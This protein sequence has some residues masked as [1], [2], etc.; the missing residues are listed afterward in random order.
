MAVVDE[1]LDVLG[2]NGVVRNDAPWNARLRAQVEWLDGRGRVVV[3]VADG[4]TPPVVAPGQTA[5]FGL[6][7]PL[8]ERRSRI[9]R[10]RLTFTTAP[11]VS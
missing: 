3:G 5:T 10:Y 6:L 11:E 2:V 1:Q 8:D 7:M 4:T 9:A